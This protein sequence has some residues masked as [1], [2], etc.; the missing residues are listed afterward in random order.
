MR[1]AAIILAMWGAALYG[2]PPRGELFSELPQISVRINA[3]GPVNLSD[4]RG[5]VVVVTFWATWCPLCRD[6]V[7]ASQRLAQA[8][9]DDVKVL[10]IGVDQSG[11]STITP[12]LRQY[13][14]RLP[15][16]LAERH[17]LHAFH[18]RDV[19]T[20]VPQTFLFDRAGRLRAHTSTALNQDALMRAVRILM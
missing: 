4:W 13:D 16:A 19:P 8:F 9:H 5:S 3:G 1:L 11:W 18:F 14:I 12:F 6:E 20:T 15:V 10:A 2:A 7:L 17:I